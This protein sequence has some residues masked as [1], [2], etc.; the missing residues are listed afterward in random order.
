VFSEFKGKT[1]FLGII[2]IRKPQLLLLEPDLVKNV[3]IRNFKNF[4]DNEFG[5]MVKK[6]FQRFNVKLKIHL[7]F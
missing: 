6:I 4:H 3:L 7:L 1:P 5:E 2:Q